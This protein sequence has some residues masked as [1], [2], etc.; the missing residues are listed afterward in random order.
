[1]KVVWMSKAR[2]SFVKTLKYVQ[3]H[4]GVGVALALYDEVDANNDYLAKN[5]YMGKIEPLLEERAIEY[6]CMIVKKL[7]KI[8]YRIDN[9]CVYIV[10]F[11]NLR[12]NPEKLQNRIK[13]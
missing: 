13:D 4:F 7:N 1:M 2:R 5:P 6:H 9:N 11:W 8:I 10:D 12:M 3:E